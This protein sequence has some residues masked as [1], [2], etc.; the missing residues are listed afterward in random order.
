MKKEIPILENNYLLDL[1]QIKQTIKANQYKAMV[2]VN[3]AMI[4]TYYQIGTII[5]QRKQWGNK[6]IQRLSYDLKEYG[7][8]YSYDN[9]KRMARFV[10]EFRAQPVPQIPWGTI[11][12]IM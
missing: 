4:Q 2:L 7:K 11:I 8:G 12:E 6:Y 1:N 10:K 9:L 5:N 3:Q